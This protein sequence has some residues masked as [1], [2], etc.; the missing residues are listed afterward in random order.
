MKS[1]PQLL[2]F[3]LIRGQELPPSNP[4]PS[5]INKGYSFKEA[6]SYGPDGGFAPAFDGNRESTNSGS[7]DEVLRMETESSDDISSGCPSPFTDLGDA[8][9]P[10]GREAVRGNDFS[11][12]LF[13]EDTSSSKDNA[14][15]AHEA[16]LSPDCREP[17]RDNGEKIIQP[18]LPSEPFGSTNPCPE[19]ENVRVC[20]P[21]SILQS[22]PGISRPS[23]ASPSPVQSI[24]EPDHNILL[25]TMTEY[26]DQF[27]KSATQLNGALKQ[28]ALEGGADAGLRLEIIRLESKNTELSA[29]IRVLTG[30]LAGVRQ[31][32]ADSNS[33]ELQ[34]ELTLDEIRGVLPA[35]W[36][37]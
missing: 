30:E 13:A 17:T 32:L 36:G 15:T 10:S 16:V 5:L 35:S 26:Y 20:R 22:D 1:R 3:L 18:S 29:A 21:T 2:P 12:T 27:L 14:T 34:L 37:Y 9:V 31:K 4:T 7:S 28:R 23:L 8:E 24:N 33:S 25:K 19:N 6:S 11:N